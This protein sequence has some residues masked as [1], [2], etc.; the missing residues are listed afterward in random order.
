MIQR[1]TAFDGF[2]AIL[3][4]ALVAFL[5]PAVPAVAD[6]D[7]ALC[8][9]VADNAND[10]VDF[11]TKIQGAQEHFIG[12]T[13]T[14]YVEAVAFQPGTGHLFGADSGR[15]V[16]LNLTTG[17]ATAV[18]N[19]GS[20]KGELG[21]QHFGDV[22]GLA[23]DPFTGKLYGSVRRDAE[24]LLIVIDPASGRAVEDAFGTHKTY[25]VVE[26]FTVNGGHKLDDIDDI[27]VDPKDGRMFGIVN[28][29]GR[30]SR[31]VTINRETGELMDVTDLDVENVEGLGFSADGTLLGVRGDS[32]KK[33]VVIDQTT[34][35]TQVRAHLGAYGGSDYESI[36]CL[37]DR[38]NTISGTVFEDKDKNGA[39]GS[40][41]RGFGGAVIKLYR[42]VNNN[43][44]IDAND[45]QLGTT[46]SDNWGEY[47]FEIS[48]VGD[49]LI[50]IHKDSL[51]AHAELTTTD[52]HTAWFG[53]FGETDS[54]NDFGFKIKHD[55]KDPALCY[56]VADNDHN[57]LHDYLTKLPASG[58]EIVIGK[59]GTQSIE[60]VAYRAS[61]GTLFAADGGRLGTLDLTTGKFTEIGE[62]GWGKGAHG[63]LEFDDVDG[64]T[65]DPFSG[66]LF[67][68]VRRVNKADLLI[69]VDPATGEAIEDAFGYGQTYITVETITVHGVEL[70][71]IDDI[72][73][74][75]YDGKLY[76][77][78]NHDGMKSRLVL[79]DKWDG[80]T[81]DLTDLDLEN[82][83]GLGFSADGTFL[84]VA[85][86][87]DKKVVVIDPATG[88]TTVRAHLG[89]GNNSDYEAIACL[90]DASNEIS[91]TVF[92][93]KNENG[94]LDYG[95]PGQGGITI[96]LYR[97][98][99]GNGQVDAHD[100]F[101]ASTVTH[102]DNGTY[103][104]LVSSLGDFVLE[105][106]L[107]TYPNNTELTT[108]NVETA[109]FT[110]FGQHDRGN[111]FGFTDATPRLIDLELTKEVDTSSP[112]VGDTVTF[113]ITVVNAGPDNA[114][115]VVVRDIIPYGLEFDGAWAS[116]GS[117][118]FMTG[119]WEIGSLKAGDAVTLDISTVV[120]IT[121]T[122]EN[123][124]QVTSAGQDDV[125][126]TPD[127][128]DP[129]EDDQDN[130]LVTAR[131][132]AAFTPADCTDMGTITA[133]VFDPVTDQLY[134][135]TETGGVHVSNDLGRSWPPFLQ[136]DN[137]LP[138]RDIVIS[139]TGVVYVG[140]E[141]AGVFVSDTAGERWNNIG[142]RDAEFFDLDLLDTRGVLYGAGRGAFS[143]GTD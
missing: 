58:S 120:T 31:L 98:K 94:K 52:L 72:A 141:G 110:S 56:L 17:A 112:K 90:T 33:V 143:S 84:G 125:D 140:T 117:Y 130:A 28:E 104:F 116:Q 64:L 122:I 103:A 133:L 101:V 135:G 18:G 61:T 99:N 60:S 80:D 95:E 5:V 40:A 102:K 113:T 69:Q 14:L 114:T 19:I 118:E 121:N 107:R 81:T 77:I 35:K 3:L 30:K 6:G 38:V 26:P 75:T 13:G 51:P 89:A 139:K 59:T 86:D 87:K 23:F 123:I 65:F 43:G 132:T 8:Y 111:D 131:S 91:G 129:E 53:G 42:D 71:D 92:R 83:E 126:S 41:D 47:E 12:E 44:R 48:S 34:G 22:D 24:D 68:S 4:T 25:L 138:I 93:D 115:G 49:F 119:F 15:L 62:F 9:L 21:V 73:I 79:V 134:A 100:V 76:G 67:A 39:F 96:K 97:D 136:T 78:L 105:S 27:A 142:P 2:R 32:D 74:D 29:E 137:R 37:T 127:N 128:S 46:T 20:G 10:G 88:Q 66:V 63:N 54:D 55:P 7:P 45:K 36:S 50:S 124:A 57:G 109:T 70:D 108:D 16:K 85:G 82:V 11:L 106:D 1:R